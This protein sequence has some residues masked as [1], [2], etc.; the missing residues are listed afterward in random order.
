[1]YLYIG[2]SNHYSMT[3]QYEF[4]DLLRIKGVDISSVLKGMC[5]VPSTNQ[6]FSF[7]TPD[8]WEVL[9]RGYSIETAF[10]DVFFKPSLAT[11]MKG[12]GQQ[13]SHIHPG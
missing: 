8:N 5:I 12:L 6:R 4:M 9:T 1:M 11:T 2:E 13:A 7:A 10:L 3:I